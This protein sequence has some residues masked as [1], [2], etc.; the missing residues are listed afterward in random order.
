MTW[1]SSIQ[2]RSRHYSGCLSA[3]PLFALIFPRCKPASIPVSGCSQIDF[4]GNRIRCLFEN[5]KILFCLDNCL[6][7]KLVKA[8]CFFICTWNLV[9]LFFKV[10][11]HKMELQLSCSPFFCT[12]MFFLS[13]WKQPKRNHSWL[14]TSSFKLQIFEN[15]IKSFTKT[16]KSGAVG[17]AAIGWAVHSDSVPCHSWHTTPLSGAKQIYWEFAQVCSIGNDVIWTLALLIFSISRVFLFYRVLLGFSLLL[18][19]SQEEAQFPCGK[20]R[21]GLRLF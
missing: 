2:P 19:F 14:N 16:C 9:S 7:L 6:V 3:S 5:N 11:H 20:H 15:S 21:V 13:G 1:P 10:C 18:H 8:Q 17:F 12:V 4:R